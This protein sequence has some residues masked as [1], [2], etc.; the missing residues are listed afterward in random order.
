ML[1]SNLTLESYDSVI[2]VAVVNA[3][4]AISFRQLQSS[5][6]NH[7]I[8][9]DISSLEISGVTVIKMKTSF[10]GSSLYLEEE[11]GPHRKFL[12]ILVASS[13]GNLSSGLE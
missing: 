13:S 9:D 4:S 3:A 12:V 11:R 6:A 5:R 2:I 8:S 10:P 7:E 1:I